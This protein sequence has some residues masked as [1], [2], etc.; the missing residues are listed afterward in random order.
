VK[1]AESDVYFSSNE[2]QIIKEAIE[3]SIQSGERINKTIL[4]TA[5]NESGEIVATFEM[6]TSLK[7]LN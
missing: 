2:G 7:V 3:E 1:R 4:V 6:I 5:K